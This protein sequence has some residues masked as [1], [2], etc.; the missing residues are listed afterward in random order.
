ML[1][2]NYDERVRAQKLMKMVM[3]NTKYPGLPSNNPI[4]RPIRTYI[5]PEKYKSVVE[6]FR[7]HPL[8]SRYNNYNFIFDNDFG[9]YF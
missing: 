3:E 2:D 7:N 1:S 5:I 4:K 6:E 9:E 8:F